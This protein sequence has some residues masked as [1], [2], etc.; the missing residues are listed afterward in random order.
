MPFKFSFPH[1]W[2]IPSIYLSI[3]RVWQ[4]SETSGAAPNPNRA[5]LIL[6]TGKH[7][8]KSQQDLHLLSLVL[9]GQRCRDHWQSRCAIGRRVGMRIAGIPPAVGYRQE[10]AALNFNRCWAKFWSTPN[11]PRVAAFYIL[12]KCLLWATFTNK[13]G[14]DFYY[15]EGTSVSLFCSRVIIC[16]FLFSPIKNSM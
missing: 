12:Q 13:K 9:I 6:P 15:F 11:S 5:R 4:T 1:S 7:V 8:E 14:R 2:N 16:S 3:E 10:T